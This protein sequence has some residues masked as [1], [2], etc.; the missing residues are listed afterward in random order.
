MRWVIIGRI[1]PDCID[2]FWR[3]CI[4]LCGYNALSVHAFIDFMHGWRL[5]EQLVQINHNWSAQLL[6]VHL[7]LWNTNYPPPPPDCT[8]SCRKIEIA[9]LLILSVITRL[10]GSGSLLYSVNSTITQRLLVCLVWF[11]DL[12]DVRGRLILNLKVD[13][14]GQIF[15]PF[16]W[17][18]FMHSCRRVHR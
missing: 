14:E 9:I 10:T 1:F 18:T 2:F 8:D 13:R 5:L 17:V 3:K 16:Q 6:M 12:Q 15:H 4:D 11:G 7:S